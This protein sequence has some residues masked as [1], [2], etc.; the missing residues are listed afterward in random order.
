MKFLSLYL[1]NYGSYFGRHELPLAGLK[2]VLVLGKNLDEPR[3]SSNG[4]LAG[5]TLIDCPRNVQNYP[6]GIP[7][8][9]LVG[10]QPWVYCWDG[11]KITIK[12]A[13]RVW[14][15][16][17]A[18]T[19]CV[20]LS[21]Y[22]TNSGA[23]QGSL[24]LPP[25]ELIGT[26]EHKV[27]LADGKTWK[28]LASLSVGDR[29]CSMYRRRSGGWRTLV[30]WTNSGSMTM[31]N[32]FGVRTFSEQ[33]LVCSIVHGVRPLGSVVHHKNENMWDHSVDNLEWLDATKHCS[34]H[35]SQRNRVGLAGWKV[36]GK[37]P[38]GM[39]G[40]HHQI[41]IREQI[42]RTM[43]EVWKC[44]KA[45]GVNHTVLSVSEGS[46]QDVF[47]IEVPEVHNFIANGIV[48]HNS[49]KSTPWEA[50]DWCLWGVV[51]RGDH[52]DSIINEESGKN[53]MVGVQ[54]EDD[55]GRL[56][57]VERFRKWKDGVDG[58]ENGLFL[59]A[60]GENQSCLDV[61]ETQKKLETILGLDREIFHAA[62]LF[63]QTDNW[64]F[65]DGTDAERIAILTRVLQLEEIDTWLIRAKE[66]HS[67]SQGELERCQQ[68]LG[69][70]QAEISSLQ[71]V[72]FQKQLDE[73]EVGRRAHIAGLEGKIAEVQGQAQTLRA[74]AGNELQ[75]QQRWQALEAST[76]AVPK[77]LDD[78]VLS[79]TEIRAR[80]DI[81]ADERKTSELTQKLLVMRTRCLGVCPECGQVVA[82]EHVDRESARLNQ[83][84]SVLAQRMAYAKTEY[85]N[86][87]MAHDAMRRT[88]ESQMLTYRQGVEKLAAEKTM[89]QQLMWE[90]QQL[91]K[92]ANEANAMVERLRQDKAG[93]EVQ[94]NPFLTKQL[95]MQNAIAKVKSKMQEL[96]VRLSKVQE[97][98]KFLDFWVDAFGPKGLKSYILDTRLGEMT[99]AV[100]QWV[101][102][103]TG[104]TFWVRFETQTLGRA[105]KLSNK[106]NIRVF[107]YGR[108]GRI[109]ERN[110]KSWSG[111]QKARV[112][113]GVDFGLARLLAA[114]AQQRYDLLILDE[115]FKHLD[116]AGREA[117]V[118]LLQV[119]QAEKSSVV[120]V[121][122]D[123][124]FGAVFE[125]VL[126]VEYKDRRS[127]IK[128]VSN[129]KEST[130][131]V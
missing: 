114:R 64:R 22:A 21:K 68:E 60:N 23:G 49:G 111:G 54:F 121:D 6:K 63:S 78:K 91:H 28:E 59:S 98:M 109:V 9:S 8:S 119:L 77:A 117:V 16:K 129:A 27:L 11:E 4:C 123:A 80:A 12:Q 105:G 50:L 108:D 120:V 32:K 39:L 69:Q 20:R 57:Q 66:L 67:F 70:K 51:P 76:P 126:T 107:Q 24:F 125:N 15:T 48:V 86:A 53:C 112:S 74:R 14:R 58:K 116:R 100:N 56:I 110:Y 99:E 97:R 10:T 89:V 34:Q 73:W 130:A 65:A 25:Q 3:M 79:E 46:V 96:E 88:F 5:D 95:E 101:K 47:D 94:M 2:L 37:H 104:G 35:T 92:Q 87:V 113:M 71:S 52:V 43:Q 82:Q 29:L 122:H 61:N 128:G 42:S 115:V 40:K 1:N 44:K 18:Q 75:F 26:P 41:C 17:K 83:E 118:E 131:T 103:L 102:L 31:G 62:I 45:S 36:S 90:S 84:L 81:M 30:Y 7:L 106:L 85:A 127:T 38:K 33:Q 13:K 72:N 19:V 93:A 124:E 55:F